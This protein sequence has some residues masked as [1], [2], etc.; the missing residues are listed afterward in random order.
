MVLSRSAI[1]IALP[2]PEFISV[3]DYLA[4]AGYEAVAVTS[5]AG[6]EATNE[7]AVTI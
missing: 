1:A 7:R 5:A 6:P 3:R 4:E 2:R